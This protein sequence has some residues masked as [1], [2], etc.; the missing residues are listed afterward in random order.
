LAGARS[1]LAAW[2]EPGGVDGGDVDDVLIAVNEACMNA[3]EHSGASADIELSAS[4]D[5][6]RLVIEVR[7]HGSWH[8]PV[9]TGDRGHGLGLMRTLMDVVEVDHGGDGTRVRMERTV[10]FGP[11]PE[12][13]PKPA[14]VDVGEVDG[15]SV[16][17]LEGD[18]DLAVVERVEAELDGAAGSSVPSLVVDL[19]RVT[20]LDSAG[21]HL[22]FKLAHRRHAAGGATRL[23]VA[24]GP[25]RRVLELTGVEATLA[26]HSSVDEAI[27]RF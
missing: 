24:P 1:A 21:V 3:V 4:L 23:A 14:S 27:A 26:M 25:V 16:A 7:D 15:V 19:T 5:G 22:L 20:Y 11:A 8:E 12:R 17:A 9:P 6:A 10:T 2:L 13:R 18:V